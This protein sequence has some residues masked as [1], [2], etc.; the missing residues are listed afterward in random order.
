ML[1]DRLVQRFEIVLMAHLKDL[2]Y[3][4]DAHLG[5]AHLAGVHVL[6]KLLEQPLVAAF[7]ADLAALRLLQAAEE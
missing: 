1:G 7:Q 6:E 5:Q 2:Q 3:L 4:L